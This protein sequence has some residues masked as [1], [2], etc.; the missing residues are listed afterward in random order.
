MLIVGRTGGGKSTIAN[1]ILGRDE[2][3]VS[4]SFKSVTKRIV[5]ATTRINLMDGTYDITVYDTVGLFDTSMMSDAQIMKVIQTYVSTHS[6]DGIHLVLFVVKKGRYSPEEKEAYDN[7]MSLFKSR[8]SSVSALVIT[9]CESDTDD[10]RTVYIRDIRAGSVTSKVA[11]FMK[12]GIYT[13]GFP[14]KTYMKPSLQ[15]LMKEYIEQD[16]QQILRLI[17]SCHEKVILEP[18]K[19]WW[20]FVS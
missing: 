16:R 7:L 10:S 11:A 19:W 17:A 1:Q 13:V 18:P 20:P 12:K 8:T 15:A 14:D 6:P 4:A 3:K 9:H 5:H 2:F